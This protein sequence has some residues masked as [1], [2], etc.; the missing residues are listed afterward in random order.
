MSDLSTSTEPRAMRWYLQPVPFGRLILVH[1][2]IWRAQRA[3][4]AGSLLALAAGLASV[5]AAT[6][7]TSGTPTAATA[8]SFLA[9]ASVAFSLLWLAIGALAACAPFKTR[10]A[11]VV[12][13]VAP[14]RAR[15]LAACLASFLLIVTAVTALFAVL[16]IAL[17]MIV[18]TVQGHSPAAAFG[19][20]RPAGVLLLPVLI[21]AMIG[22]ALGA[23][24]RSVAASIIVGYVLAPL[25][26]MIKIGSAGIGRWL[27]LTGSVTAISSGAATGAALLPAVT[28]VLFWVILPSLVAWFRLRSPI[29]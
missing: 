16:S 23:A 13:T 17:V 26:P 25:A 7:H 9:F 12:L 22:F 29:G 3:V 4:V 10:W 6:A 27:D 1:L 11:L 24:T 14:R 28:A 19:V 20:A 15:W 21:Q 2:R 8:E 5:T 18:L